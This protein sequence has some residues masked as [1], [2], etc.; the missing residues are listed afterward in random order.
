MSNQLFKIGLF[1]VLAWMGALVYFSQ[2]AGKGF[3]G[4]GEVLEWDHEDLTILGKNGAVL[5]ELYT[6]T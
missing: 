5:V 6:P 1:L 4:S 2:D 3:G